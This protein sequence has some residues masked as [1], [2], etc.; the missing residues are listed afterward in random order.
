MGS[1]DVADAAVPGGKTP[2]R[3][4]K[5]LWRRRGWPQAQLTTASAIGL[6]KKM[7]RLQDPPPGTSEDA[8]DELWDTF[9]KP[10]P[11]AIARTAGRQEAARIVTR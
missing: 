7:Y 6:Q 10:L 3:D 9:E 2:L 1:V 5:V 8:V 11:S 4:A